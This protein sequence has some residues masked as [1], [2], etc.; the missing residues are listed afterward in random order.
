MTTEHIFKQ[1]CAESKVSAADIEQATSTIAK[2]VERTP[3]LSSPELDTWL[4]GDDNDNDN[5]IAQ[6]FFKGEHVQKTGS[7]KIRGVSNALS[8]VR[9]VS[10]VVTHSSGN[11]GMAVAAACSLL[12]LRAHVV[13][14]A[15]APPEKIAKITKYGAKY[16]V[17]AASM[18]ARELT[19][20]GIVDGTTDGKALLLHSSNHPD[21]VA[22][23][24]TVASEL[25]EQAGPLDA[26]VVSVGGGGLAGGC[27]VAAKARDLNIA[28]FGAEPER[29]N[30]AALSFEKGRRVGTRYDVDTVADGLRVSVQE[31]GWTIIRQLMEEVIVV[32]EDDTV[33]AVDMVWKSLGV[34]VEGSAGVAVAAAKKGRLASRGYKRVGIVLCGGNVDMSK[35]S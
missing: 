17:C 30:A 21:V 32:S 31:T 2:L 5:A 28:V 33:E 4:S 9:G 12:G 13:V 8:K 20:Q 34:A 3:V 14:P 19:A 15:T 29:C 11:H 6:F 27:A 22:G 16:T 7:F 35:F 18:E 1:A 26:I 23:Q 10:T 25:L 24:G